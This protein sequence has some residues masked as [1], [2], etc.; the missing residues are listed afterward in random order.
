MCQKKDH[1]FHLQGI[2]LFTCRGPKN[3]KRKFAFFTCRGHA[4]YSQGLHFSLTGMWKNAKSKFSL[5]TGRG[6]P[7]FPLVGPLKNPKRK[8]ALFTCRGSHFL[9]AVA[10]LFTST[11]HTFHLQGCEKMP[12]ASSPFL[13]V[14]GGPHFSL[15]GSPKN[16]ERKFALFTCGDPKKCQKKVHTY[17]LQRVWNNASISWSPCEWKGWPPSKW[18]VFC[19]HWQR[20]RHA[21]LWLTKNWNCPSTLNTNKSW[22]G[23]S[24]LWWTHSLCIRSSSKQSP[25]SPACSAIH[26]SVPSRLGAP[27][28]GLAL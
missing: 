10:T 21:S 19:R 6:G 17:H 2:T 1:I 20:I 5:F 26:T 16:V 13:L 18:K 25:V 15:V 9:L 24:S 3:A 22:L 14:G 7:H 23:E 12:K 4:F 8:F 11:G 28:L 27:R